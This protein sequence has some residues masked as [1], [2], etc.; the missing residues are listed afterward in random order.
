MHKL[1]LVSFVLISYNQEDFIESAIQ[2]ALAQDYHP[3]QVIISDD[4]STDSTWK[5]IQTAV[6]DYH[7]T[8]EILL[9]RNAHNLGIARHVDFI[10]RVATGEFV[11]FAPA[12]DISYKNRTKTL[13]T[14]WLHAAP[15][16]TLIHSNFRK[17][18]SNG[19]VV[20]L[21]YDPRLPRS[22]TQHANPYAQSL[23]ISG[24]TTAFE[25]KIYSDFDT[26]K[27]NIFAE[28]A[29]TFHRAHL[30]NGILY[31]PNILLDY[32]VHE[33]G[34]SQKNSK[35]L[36]NY[37]NIF[38]RFIP[39]QTARLSQYR[40]DIAQISPSNSGEL[41][42]AVYRKEER[43]QLISQILQGSIL[44]SF[45]SLLNSLFRESEKKFK[46]E[47]LKL[48]IFRWLAACLRFRSHSKNRI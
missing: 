37:L 27:D 15:R 45:S 19:D 46:K 35:G 9:N 7:G 40:R 8:H 13:V 24:A 38:H 41:L 20:G 33:K 3:L 1:P 16:P 31:I 43:I 30:L 47:I 10:C 6:Q 14:A 11:I 25:R 2:A 36:N 4:C 39:E 26:I 17:V 48:F 32:R 34:T 22:F 29:I 5:K 42:S 28:D 44:E 21:G 18:T 12:D 23:E